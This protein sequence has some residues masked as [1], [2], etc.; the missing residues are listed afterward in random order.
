M[1]K[2]EDLKLL[3]QKCIETQHQYNEYSKDDLINATI[4]FLDVLTNKIYDR[5]RDIGSQGSISSLGKAAG[6][7]LKDF[8]KKHTNIDL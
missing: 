1:N 6:D 8:V 7:E 4:V 2:N 3:A 5:Y